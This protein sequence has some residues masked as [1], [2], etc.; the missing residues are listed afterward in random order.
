MGYRSRRALCVP[1]T[2][3]LP[4]LIV[5]ALVGFFLA[6]IMMLSLRPRWIRMAALAGKVSR[7]GEVMTLIAQR[8]STSERVQ[9]LDADVDSMQREHKG[10]EQRLQHSL[11][12]GLADAARHH[13][14]AEQLLSQLTDQRQA[15]D[16][17]RARFDTLSSEHAGLRASAAEQ[18][19]GATAKLELLD[20]AEERLRETF[21]NLANQIL[22]AKAERFQEQSTTQLGGVLD[23]LKLQ[24]KEFREAVTQT[25]ATEQRERGMLVEQI[26]NLKELNQK[27]SEDAINLTRALK[28]ESRTQGA[29]GELVLER[30]LEA[31]GLQAGREYETQT[32]FSDAEGA[33][34][35]PDVIVHLP[36]EK[37]IVIDAKVSLVAWERSLSSD[38]DIESA[39]AMR[40]HVASLKRHVDGLSAKRYEN[41]E[42]IRTLDFVLLFVPIEAAFIE[43][44]RCDENL[45][46]YALS[47]NVSLVSPSTL[48][49][50]LRT[51][52]HLWRIERRNENATEIARKAALLHDNFVLLATDLQKVGLQLDGAQR[53]HAAA[54]RRITEGGRGSVILQVNNLA[55]LGSPVQK[56]IPKTLLQAAG[57]DGDGDGDGDAGDA[58]ADIQ[59]R[60]IEDAESNQIDTL[61]T[62]KD[63]DN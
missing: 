56:K 4:W 34:Q 59:P 43:A 44:V 11:Q 61:A 51:V 58:N 19:K 39:A 21:Q 54:L 50:T 24:L 45:Y 16:S 35:R 1:Q 9:E 53:S 2:F 30:V 57:A 5:A 29:W 33:R 3:E 18:A 38:D 7:D 36:D 42:G 48:L 8:D 31:S 49:A 37:D 40:E 27:I 10:I 32:S 15:L 62:N 20:K 41:I 52:T 60:L 14:R 28:G 26:R 63:G 47:R 23:P 17:T 25:H 46:T 55:E 6:A 12:E 13:A 22:E